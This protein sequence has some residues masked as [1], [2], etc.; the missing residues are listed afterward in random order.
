MSIY[1]SPLLIRCRRPPGSHYLELPFILTRRLPYV[2]LTAE[3]LESFDFTTTVS[4]PQTTQSPSLSTS[5]LNNPLPNL[6]LPIPNTECCLPK[7][8]IMLH[9]I[10][11]NSQRRTQ[12][13]PCHL[14]VIH[15]PRIDEQLIRPQ[16]MECPPRHHRIPQHLHNVRDEDVRILQ[17]GSHRK[18]RDGSAE[19]ARYDDERPAVGYTRRCPCCRSGRGVGDPGGLGNCGRERRWVVAVSV[20]LNHEFLRDKMGGVRS[21]DRPSIVGAN[22]ASRLEGRRRR[23]WRCKA[24]GNDS[25]QPC[26]DGEMVR[27]HTDGLGCAPALTVDARSSGGNSCHSSHRCHIPLPLARGKGAHSRRAVTRLHRSSRRAYCEERRLCCVE[28]G[29]KVL[30]EVG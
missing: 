16:E 1:C 5:L 14:V 26:G 2:I 20:F 8:L 21:G 10:L 19:G 27:S 22:L 13:T 30:A 23:K 28:V 3:S 7:Q 4:K 15:I 18:R 25:D 17:Q 24:E 12:N 6:I 9:E 11:Q 29:A